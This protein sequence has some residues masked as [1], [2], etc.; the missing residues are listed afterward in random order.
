MIKH[1]RELKIY[2]IRAQDHDML[3]VKTFH[4]ES[5]ITPTITNDL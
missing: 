3:K 4:F 1:A 5:L 2:K